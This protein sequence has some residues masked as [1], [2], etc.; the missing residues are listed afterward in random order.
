MNWKARVLYI[1]AAM[2]TGVLNA[3]GGGHSQTA[4]VPARIQI[5][6]AQVSSETIDSTT[7]DLSGTGMTSIHKK[8]EGVPTSLELSGITPGTSRS[9]VVALYTAG[10]MVQKGDATFD[11]IAGESRSIAVTLH[12]LF[13][14]LQMVVPLGLQNASGVDHGQLLL[15]CSA[16]PDTL[17]LQGVLPNKYFRSNSLELG[18][19]YCFVVDLYDST[20]RALYHGSDTVHLDDQTPT[21]TLTL[22]SLVG[23]ISLQ[24]I[25]QTNAQLTGRISLPNSRR[26][27]P[28]SLHDVLILELLPN[29]KSSGDEWEYT[30]IFNA[31]L[32]TLVLDSCKLAKS[33][34]SVTSTTAANLSGCSVLP[35]QFAVIGRDSVSIRTCSAGGFT[36]ANTAQS[37]VVACG[38]LLV[39]S[40]AYNSPIDSLNPFPLQAGK[41]I[42]V[43]LAKYTLRSQGNSWCA[44]KDSVILSPGFGVLGSPGFDAGC[45]E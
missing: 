36:L 3:C 37:V 28:Q 43:P 22:G 32:D 14:T 29:P 42:E 16:S 13:G 8:W 21:I 12:S 11:V 33:R 17:V 5:A 1:G 9:I 35:G 44:G 34:A 39:D 19:D 40:I 15:G 23:A 25:I 6:L 38:N 7:V 27:A 20:G 4:S 26:R 30:E 10:R 18:K 2:L 45:V 41:S 31:T 24:L